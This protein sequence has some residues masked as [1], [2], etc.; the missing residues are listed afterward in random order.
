M[1][2]FLLILILCRLVLGV[3]SAAGENYRDLTS[4][5]GKTIRAKVL[6]YDE[7]SDMA[8]I[9]RDDH[10]QYTVSP[11]LFCAVDKRMIRN[12]GLVESFMNDASLKVS[13]KHIEE[14]VDEDYHRTLDGVDP[15]DLEVQDYICMD[16]YQI[17]LD[18]RTAHAFDILKSKPSCS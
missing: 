5:D 17:T 2:Y 4:A 11:E 14:R 9:E 18:N 15:E 16:H 6:S 12:W 7:S 1:K 8:V 13:I 10:K 3:S